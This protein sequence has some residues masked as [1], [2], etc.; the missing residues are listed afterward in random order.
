MKGPHLYKRLGCDPF[1]L[2][3]GEPHDAHR[4]SLLILSVRNIR[5]GLRAR[6]DADWALTA[7]HAPV[8]MG[9][10]DAEQTLAHVASKVNTQRSK[11]TDTRLP[12]VLRAA[13]A[14]SLHHT[15]CACQVMRS[16]YCYRRYHHLCPR[17]H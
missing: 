16:N 8:I 5:A 9:L 11:H 2:P 13:K 15:H 12:F 3:P 6:A 7:L 1:N 14:A 10:P 4:L 17:Y